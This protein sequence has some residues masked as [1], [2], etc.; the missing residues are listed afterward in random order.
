MRQ[1]LFY[2]S[3]IIAL[4]AHS[5]FTMPDWQPDTW[6]RLGKMAMRDFADIEPY[7]FV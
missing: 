2:F 4:N 3:A 6:Q 7:S 5:F 1:K